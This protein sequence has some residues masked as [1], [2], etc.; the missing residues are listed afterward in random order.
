MDV[1]TKGV[2]DA[3]DMMQGVREELE[4]QLSLD[5]FDPSRFQHLFPI[6]ES[7]VSGNKFRELIIADFLRVFDTTCV[8]HSLEGLEVRVYPNEIVRQEL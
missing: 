8:K 2:C 1:N 7:S 6:T 3:L 5:I 4:S